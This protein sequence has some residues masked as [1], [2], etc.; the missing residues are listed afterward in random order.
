MS[1]EFSVI[2]IFTQANFVFLDPDSEHRIY[3]QRAA[4][5]TDEMYEYEEIRN[6]VIRDEEQMNA[7]IAEEQLYAVIEE[8]VLEAVSQ[9]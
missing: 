3:Q 1:R 4:A 2:D 6:F 5:V 8:E 9:N 7:A